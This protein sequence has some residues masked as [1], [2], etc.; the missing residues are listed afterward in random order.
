MKL[1][2]GDGVVKVNQIEIDVPATK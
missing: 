2:L 1:A